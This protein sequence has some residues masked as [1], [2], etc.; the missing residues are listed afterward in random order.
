MIGER[1]YWRWTLSFRRAMVC[2]PRAQELA[3]TSPIWSVQLAR[4][5]PEMTVQLSQSLQT[6][7]AMSARRFEKG[8]TE[9]I[10]KD[11]T[12]SCWKRW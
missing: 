11:R 2:H 5:E 3:S 1:C 6:L 10:E 8:F 9:L 4:N 7:E 12:S